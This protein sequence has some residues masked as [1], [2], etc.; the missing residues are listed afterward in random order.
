MIIAVASGKG[1]TGKTTVATNLAFSLKDSGQVQLLDCDVEEPNCHLFLDVGLVDETHV[2]VMTPALDATRCTLCGRCQ[3]VCAFNAIALLGKQVMVFPELCHGC[4]S[5][6]YF[7]P[8]GALTEKTR[9]IGVVRRGKG[10]RINLVYGLLNIG[11]AIAIPIIHQL[12]KEL[13]HETIAI[14]DVPP[15]TSCPMVASVTGA[16]FCL[17][18]TEPTPVGL[19]DLKLAIAVVQELGIPLGVVV[20]R[21]GLG[22]DSVYEYCHRHNVPILLEIPFEQ[23]FAQVYA[24]G[25]LISEDYPEWQARFQ[26]L[27][28]EIERKAKE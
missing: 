14:L 11:E 27:F 15:G 25:R 12:K 6:T 1:G 26:E 28:A 7:C 22:D 2:E 8:S 4:A 16:D 5:C 18:I 24:Q 9:P 13:R 17:L 20:N 3:E 21:A 23:R 19:S 10:K